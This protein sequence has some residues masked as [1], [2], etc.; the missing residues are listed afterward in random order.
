MTTSGDVFG[1]HQLEG[2][3][4]ISESEARETAAHPTVQRTASLFHSNEQ[5]GLKCQQE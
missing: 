2:M 5:E 1:C 4:S 3:S